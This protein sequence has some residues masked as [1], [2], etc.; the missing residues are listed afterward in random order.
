MSLTAFLAMSLLACDVMI[1]LF[2]QWTFAEKYRSR[3]RR[4]AAR[5]KAAKAESERTYARI[6][7]PRPNRRGTEFKAA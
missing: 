1:F 5:K 3:G 7:R 4:V 2:F 6:P